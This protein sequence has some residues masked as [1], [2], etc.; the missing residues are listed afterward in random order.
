M[1]T[2]RS[3]SLKN[4]GSSCLISILLLFSVGC[5]FQL[6]GNLL[7]PTNLQTLQIAPNT[8]FEPFQRFLRQTLASN[9]VKILE[10]SDEEAKNVPVLTILSQSFNERTVGYGPDGQVNRSILQLTVSFQLTD[11]SGKVLLP[12]SSVQVERAL[13]V[14]P[15]AVLGTQ[16]ERERLKTDLYMDAISQMLRQMSKA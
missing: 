9:G 8:P 6:R 15:N 12:P 11:P 16:N 5:G 10:P 4:L 1:K 14:N 2:Y 7:I 13:T 3:Y